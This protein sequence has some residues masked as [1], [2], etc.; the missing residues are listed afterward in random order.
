MEEQTKL[1]SPLPVVV[2]ADFICPYSYIAQEQVDQ[3]MRD[4]NVRVM[5]KPYWLHPDVPPEGRPIPTT[6]DPNRRQA[7]MAWLKE[8]APAMAARIKSPT[9]QQFSF[10]AFEAMEF[11]EEQGLDQPMRTA[12]FDALWVEDGDIGDVATLLKAGE[13]VGLNVPALE[14]SLSEHTY[15]ERT[16][17][18]IVTARKSGIHLTPTVILGNTKI[19]GWHFYE[20]FESVLEKQ[21]IQPKK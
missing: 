3:L 17:Q 21:G 15:M 12:I 8:M 2:F 4:Y 6:A 20:V 16:L 19:E 9:K 10:F 11:A 1:G 13:K 14:R 7:T 18:N 5:W